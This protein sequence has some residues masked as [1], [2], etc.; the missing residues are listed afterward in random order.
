VFA[1][2]V[3]VT[4]KE[5]RL[6]KK[7]VHLDQREEVITELQT[8]L[9]TYNK[10]LEEQRDQQD[11]IVEDLRKVQQGLDDRASSLALAEEN[12]KEKDASLDKRAADLAWREKDPAFREEMLE[13]RDKLLANYELEAEEKERTLGE[14]VRQFEA[15]QAAQAAQV[16]QVASGS[17]AVEAMR[18]TLEDLWAEHHTGVQYIAAWAGE[19]SL[20][21]VPLGVSPIPVFEQSASISDALPV[22]D[23]TANRLRCLDQILG[24]CLEAESSRLCQ[25]VIEYVLTCFRS[26]DPAISLASVI[27]GP[28]A[29][30][31]VAAR[32]GIQDA[33]D[34]VAERFQRDPADDE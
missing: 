10:M 26:Y 25:S 11:T 31:E 16:A 33:V 6:A 30:T 29:D 27:A 12:L 19:A 20:A 23:S 17:K 7:E 9:N 5:K 4:G 24:A 1:Q 32:E 13:R 34:A 22:L 15:V 14:R 21:L 2:E 28:V 8:K 18:K 3:E